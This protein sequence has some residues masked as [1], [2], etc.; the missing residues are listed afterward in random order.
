M[1]TRTLQAFKE[2][3]KESWSHFAP[4]EAVTTPPAARLVRHAR[5]KPGQRILD[6]GCGTGVVAITA[7][8]L[9]AHAIGLDLT[10]ALLERARW[11]ADV[12][13]VTV[14]WHEGDAEAIPFPDAT[15]DVVVSQF[16]HMFAPRSDVAVAEMLRVV[17]PGGTLAFSTWPPELF[18][19]RMFGV[20]A[21]YGPPPPDGMV[22]P[23]LWGEVDVVR[24]RL[25]DAVRDLAFDRDRMLVPALSPRHHRALSQRTAGPV[26]RVV[27]MLS[28]SDPQRLAA[29]CAEYDTLVEEYF[30]GNVVRADY[31]MTRA[32][33]R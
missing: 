27:D 1:D 2:S 29:F 25:G 22:P 18:M 21:R 11:N 28:Q 8:R 32:V 4:L 15:C 16:G 13:G 6:V 20:V 10:P 14:E 3:Q 19:G 24:Q 7:A 5:V 30:D 26:T 12:A 33:K 23:V 31:L 17:R 9:G